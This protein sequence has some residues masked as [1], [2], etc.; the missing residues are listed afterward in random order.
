MLLAISHRMGNQIFIFFIISIII[1]SVKFPQIPIFNILSCIIIASLL[2]FIV[3][4]GQINKV[5]KDHY[6][7]LKA[8]MRF[9]NQWDGKKKL[10]SIKAIFLNSPLGFLSIPC[11]LIHY[12]NSGINENNFPS[13]FLI[14]SILI[15]ALSYFWIW[16][17]G[18]RHIIFLTPFIIYYIVNNIDIFLAALIVIL[19][20]ILKLRDL[21]FS[22]K[23]SDP[24][25]EYI[26]SEW[27][28]FSQILKDLKS[29]R[30]LMIPD[31]SLSFLLYNSKKI[32]IRSAHD[33][34]S[35][36]FDRTMLKWKLND[37]KYVLNFVKEMKP[38]ILIKKISFDNHILRNYVIKNFLL[39]D[40]IKGYQIWIRNED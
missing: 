40:S 18:E 32:W 34:N 8:H 1:F 15:V 22:W 16:G 17:S 7:R 20:I 11:M 2:S 35:I 3:T 9:G 6:K 24:S 21:I 13:Y 30:I 14:I 38:G 37:Q 39:I 29:D 25:L 4:K 27:V 12:N 10:G 33:S 31:R 23:K 5:L 19:P 28:N 36:T 26:D